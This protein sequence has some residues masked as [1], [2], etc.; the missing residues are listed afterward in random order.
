MTT[1]GVLWITVTNKSHRTQK[2]TLFLFFHHFY[3]HSNNISFRY[4]QFKTRYFPTQLP[5]PGSYSRGR[6]YLLV[7]TE[8]E[9]RPCVKS[10]DFCCEKALMWIY[11][12]TGTRLPETALSWQRSWPKFKRAI[13]CLCNVWLPQQWFSPGCRTRME[14]LRW[15]RTSS[16]STSLGSTDQG[17]PSSP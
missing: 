2:E 11:G 12:T 15:S 10:P 16:P 7:Q 1:T 8:T 13:P 5:I 3:L 17:I 14:F 4:C 9:W 6:R